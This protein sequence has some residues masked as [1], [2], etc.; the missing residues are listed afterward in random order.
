M[1][2]L[3]RGGCQCAAVRYRL[4]API[5]E[6]SC[7]HCQQCRKAN[8]SAF[9]AAAPVP[10][11]KFVLESGTEVL[12]S[13]ES[14]PGKQRV[15][16]ANCGSP[17]YSKH[18]KVPGVIRLRPGTLD[19]PAEHKADYHIFAVDKADW[20]VIADGLPQYPGFKPAN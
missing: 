5:T 18:V 15:F 14:S 19:G 9:V 11:D 6:I 17:I 16:C 8:G 4:E 3:H 13:F 10:E 12:R 7:C 1:S 2:A 20:E